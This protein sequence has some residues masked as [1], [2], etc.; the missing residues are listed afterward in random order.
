[1]TPATAST[2]RTADA[3][4]SR[5]DARPGG[6]WVARGGIGCAGTAGAADQ[7]GDGDGARGCPPLDIE[8]AT[9]QVRQSLALQLQARA[10]LI[11]TLNGGV[12]YFRHDGAQ[13]NIFTG[14]NFRKGRQDCFVGGRAEPLCRHHRWD[15]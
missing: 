13:Q 4:C 9:V 1:M 6:G 10:L 8:A 2:A 14:A 5:T 7:P 12:D 15:L 3:V 11:P